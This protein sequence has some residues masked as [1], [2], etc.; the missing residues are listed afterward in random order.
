M[1]K[2]LSIFF[3]FYVSLSFAQPTSSLTVEKIMRDA[4]WMGVSPSNIQWDLNSTKLYFNWNPNGVLRDPLY[5]ITPLSHI[6]QL[7]SDTLK[8]SLSRGPFIYSKDR[9]KVLF[10]RDGDIILANAKTGLE[11]V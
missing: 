8:R 1:K 6:P 2:T 5:H 9:S 3:L 11:S 7:S 10:E 4:K